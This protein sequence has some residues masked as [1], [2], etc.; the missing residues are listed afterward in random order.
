M[1][2]KLDG[3]GKSMKKITYIKQEI[4]SY[5]E[6][7]IPVYVDSVSIEEINSENLDCILEDGEY[8]KDIQGVELGKISKVNYIKLTQH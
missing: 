3:E 7:N 2:G 1:S 5:Q 4:V 8:M 6:N